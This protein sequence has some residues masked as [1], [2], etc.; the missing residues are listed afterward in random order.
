MP[1]VQY[2]PQQGQLQLS[3]AEQRDLDWSMLIN[4]R[5]I[6]GVLQTRPG[7][8]ILY[9]P[10]TYG[11]V[12]DVNTPDG[13]AV[14]P[15][16]YGA[17]VTDGFN[18]LGSFLFSS[19]DGSEYIFSIVNGGT[20]NIFEI[21]TTGGQFVYTNT[22]LP[23]ENGIANGYPNDLTPDPTDEAYCFVRWYD[24]VFFCNGGYLWKWRP[25]QAMYKPEVVVGY[26]NQYNVGAG[27]YVTG[28]IYGPSIVAVHHDSLVISGFKADA[29]LNF[30]TSVYVRNSG[31][32][33]NPDPSKPG[34]VVIGP[35]GQSVRLNPYTL[36]FSDPVAPECF[37]ISSVYQT[38]LLSAVSALASHSGRLV[39]WSQSEMG[40]ISGATIDSAQISFQLIST[41]IGCMSKRGHC[42]TSEGLLVFL[43]DTNVYAWEGNGVPVI[44]SE[45][46][47]TLFRQ[48]SQSFWRWNFTPETP[49][50]AAGT[51]LPFRIL[52]S[53]SDVSC[54]VWNSADGY[55]AIAVT[56]GTQA[57]SNDLTICWSPSSK[58]WWIDTCQPTTPTYSLVTRAGNTF[59]ELSAVD[60][61]SAA[62]GKYTLM[63]SDFE[64]GILFSQAFAYDSYSTI[65]AP[66]T[67]ICALRGQT[68]SAYTTDD[69]AKPTNNSYSFLAV[70]A[71]V[72]LGDSEFKLQRRLSMR[73]MGISSKDYSALTPI[74]SLKLYVIPEDGHSDVVD[75]TS[76]I[77]VASEQTMATA[78]EG[79]V[80]PATW[81]DTA[82]GI[83]A[84]MYG[85]TGSLPIG[86]QQSYIK[87][88]YPL[89]PVDRRLDIPA[90]VT[91]WFR[92]GLGKVV[93]EANSSPVQILSTSVELVP[94]YGTRRG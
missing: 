38:P 90:R 74:Y 21:Y 89:A 52:T 18:P 29:V 93:S 69:D 82:S 28:A 62:V 22:L 46:I 80:N 15:S 31:T 54:A 47:Q 14:F 77:S 16:S 3:V 56:S 25:L 48:G 85:G 45:Q 50:L 5:I 4:G 34:S 7:W 40:I 81:V 43:G 86:W 42:Q 44:I 20:F 23:S 58:Q 83:S 94:N 8:E 75:S 9:A 39:V 67:V 59:W 51:G 1:T 55:V 73:T 78:P 37:Q 91:Q 66:T 6:D 24:T 64:P 65:V 57:E 30:E 13:A 19:P 72:A 88:W 17:A 79:V 49:D 33:V 41:G 27:N 87:R 10:E 12:P 70:S 92:I 11:T 84:G 35:N 36:V 60:A 76:T 71:P 53:R 2:Q 61:K 26:H 32:Q 68:D 63:Q